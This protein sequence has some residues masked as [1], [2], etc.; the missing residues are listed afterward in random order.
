MRR[1]LDAARDRK[2]ARK[3]QLDTTAAELTLE[4]K[5]LAEL[6]GASKASAADA[7]TARAQVAGLQAWLDRAAA[8]VEAGSQRDGKA[9]P[10]RRVAHRVEGPMGCAPESEIRGVVRATGGRRPGRRT[11]WQL[12]VA[13]TNCRSRPIVTVANEG[14]LTTISAG[15]A[16]CGGAVAE[17]ID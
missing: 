10:R 11:D 9:R 6:R 5:R 13:A 1:Q 8:L 4:R 3:G 2:D 16:E 7:P 12:P 15:V 14:R 17:V